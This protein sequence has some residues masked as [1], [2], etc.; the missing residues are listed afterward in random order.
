MQANKWSFQLGL[1][2]SYEIIAP[3]LDEENALEFVESDVRVII[4]DSQDGPDAFK[5]RNISLPMF[6]KRAGFHVTRNPMTV[7]EIYAFSHVLG[8]Q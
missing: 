6:C 4:T 8:V 1:S 7:G 3:A 2:R 5:T